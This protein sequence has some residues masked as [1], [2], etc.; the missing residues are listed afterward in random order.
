MR[1]FG[2]ILAL[3]LLSAIPAGAAPSTG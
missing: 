3:L 2:A 1:F